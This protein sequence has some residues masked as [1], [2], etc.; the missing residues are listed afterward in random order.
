VARQFEQVSEQLSIGVTESSGS[1]VVTIAGEIDL[2]SAP[3]LRERLS[4]CMDKGCRD[5]TLEMSGVSFMDSSGIKALLA[6]RGQ[7]EEV[8]GRLTLS[9]PSRTVLRVLD[10]TG[11]SS[12][13]AITGGER[14]GCSL[15]G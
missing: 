4:Q 14:D 9:S 15:M 13:F 7:L 12:V 3:S 2:A 6:A 10:V 11:L 5:I 1:A 8:D